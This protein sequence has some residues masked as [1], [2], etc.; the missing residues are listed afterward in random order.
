MNKIIVEEFNNYKVVKTNNNYLSSRHNPDREAE[1][2]LDK[3]KDKKIIFL[4]GLGSGYLIK[5]ILSI[6]TEEQKII[7][8]EKEKE[9]INIIANIHNI[10]FAN[11]KNLF[12]ISENIYILSNLL[13]EILSIEDIISYEI[14][15][16]KVQTDIIDNEFY[17]EVE[18]IILNTI[19]DVKQN[20]F[21]KL[22][23]EKDWNKNAIINSKH[24]SSSKTLYGFK[25][26]FSNVP[27]ILIGAGPS[28]DKNI[29]ILKSFEDKSIII[30]VDTALRCCINNNIKPDFIFSLDCNRANFDDFIGISTDELRIIY[31]MVVY[32]RIIDEFKG[33][34][35]LSVTGHEKYNEKMECNIEFI[36]FYNWLKSIAKIELPYIQTGGSVSHSAFDTLR[37]FG[38]NPIILIGQDLAYTNF[39][40]HT[41]WNINTSVITKFSPLETK[42][43]NFVFDRNLFSI[44]AYNGEK[45]YTD[46]IF[47][48][49]LKWFENAGRLLHSMI[50]LINATEGGA[51]IKYFQN[52]KLESALKKYCKNKIDKNILNSNDSFFINYDDIKNNAIEKINEL[53]KVIK[54]CDEKLELIQNIYKSKSDINFDELEEF[55]KEILNTEPY[56]IKTFLKDYQYRLLSLNKENKNKKEFSFIKYALFFKLM[57]EGAEYYLNIFNSNFKK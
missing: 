30:A 33:E 51:F 34:K 31:D 2:I 47:Y 3:I 12:I 8:I 5:K 44:K 24:F 23:L 22:F 39:K 55:K 26:K 19:R 25:N 4:L 1:R 53:E 15:K 40:D 50:T 37:I 41:I 14:V 11:N 38:C 49:Y 46:A 28:L 13:F 27:G 6:K 9:L 54:L 10:N 56:F 29:K 17:N 7:V 36:E 18:T 57:K 45:V 43:F 42:F 16:N 32:P 35:Y 20:F 48:G 52:M 21:T